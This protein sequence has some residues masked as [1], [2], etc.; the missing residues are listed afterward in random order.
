MS[1]PFWNDPDFAWW[2]VMYLGGRA[3]PGAWRIEGSKERDVDKVKAPDQDGFTL[4]NKGYAG[5]SLR[6]I[7][8]LWTRQQLD[9]FWAIANDYDPE[10]VTQASPYDLYHPSSDILWVNLVYV[11]K[12][13]VTGPSKGIYTVTF[14]LDQWMPETKVE[15]TR[16]T[17]KAKGTGNETS[18]GPQGFD[19][20][21]TGGKPLAP[22]DF[23][24]GLPTI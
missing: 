20:A 17:S 18:G 21:Q 7:G 3:M 15:P 10:F 13:S 5:G 16:N 2:D 4:T 11:R 9:D 12:L 24:L 23:E 1:Y 19:G 6:A 14:E 22:E 8:Q